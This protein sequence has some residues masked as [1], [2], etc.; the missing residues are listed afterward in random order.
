M[1]NPEAIILDLSQPRN[2]RIQAAF[3]LGLRGSTKDIDLLVKAM[4][5][6]PSPV[7]RHECAFALGETAAMFI[8]PELIKAMQQ[9]NNPFVVHEAALALGTLG[10]KRALGPLREL[11]KH[12]NADLV[13][14]AEIAIERLL[15]DEPEIN[16]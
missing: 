2:S 7:V 12:H 10:D 9:D 4:F 13:E 5:T 1:I 15:T 8:V 16:D 11:C 6:D 3:Q 14:S